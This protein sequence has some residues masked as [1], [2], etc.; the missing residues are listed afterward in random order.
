MA[1]TALG[2]KTSNKNLTKLATI[3]PSSK[4]MPAWFRSQRLGECA[5][6]AHSKLVLIPPVIRS[7]IVDF[8]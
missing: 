3:H 6:S 8:C 4:S 5:N 7:K 2:L 1:L